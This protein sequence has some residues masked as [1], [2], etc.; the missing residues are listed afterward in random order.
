MAL[1]NRPI[2]VDIKDKIIYVSF[3]AVL[4]N[5]WYGSANSFKIYCNLN[6]LF[7]VLAGSV[8][9]SNNEQM[10]EVARPTKEKVF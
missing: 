8:A 7:S 10:M 4:V 1:K 9:V 6:S 2:W 5:T 3:P